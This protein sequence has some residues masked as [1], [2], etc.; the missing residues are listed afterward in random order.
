MPRT[1]KIAR[2]FFYIFLVCFFSAWGLAAVGLM[3]GL[4]NSLAYTIFLIVVAGSV[5]YHLSRKLR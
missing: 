3:S 1:R 5:A 2:W 4:S